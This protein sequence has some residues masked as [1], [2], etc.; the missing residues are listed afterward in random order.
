MKLAQWPKDRSIVGWPVNV[1]RLGY[2]LM[3]AVSTYVMKWSLDHYFKKAQSVPL[4]EVHILSS[5]FQGQGVFGESHRAGA[6][7]LLLA[8]AGLFCLGTAA[9]MLQP[10]ERLKVSAAMKRLEPSIPSRGRAVG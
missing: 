3:P 5:L 1:A 8:A 6:G 10:Y 4:T 2:A 7:G 9:H